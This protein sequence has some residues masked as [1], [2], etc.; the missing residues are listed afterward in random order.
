[1]K[2]NYLLKIS[3]YLFNLSNESEDKDIIATIMACWFKANAL[4]SK[5]PGFLKLAK[6]S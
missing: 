5:K 2:N 4:F 3:M 1:M 6:I